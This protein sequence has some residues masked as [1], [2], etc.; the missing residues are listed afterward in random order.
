VENLLARM[1]LAEKVA[2]LG[3]AWFA[4]LVVD[5]DL[6]AERMEQ[7]LGQ[8]IGHISGIAPQSGRGPEEL[9]RF[10]NGIQ[11]FL[12]EHTRLGIPA[13]VHEEAVAGLCARGASQFPQ[14]IGLASTWDPG[15]VE[16]VAASC[17]RHL[18]AVGARAALSP[19]VD[20]ALD[21]RWGRLEETYGEDPELTSR[22]AVAYVRGMQGDDLAYGVAATAKH[23]VAH[24]LPEGGFNHGAV[25]IGARRLR[26]VVAAPFRATVH[27][28]GLANVMSAY[29]EV[30][31]LP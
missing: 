22:L 12:V 5:G 7:H 13:I 9:A 3:G 2:Q 30:D 23:F 29:H 24:G 6:D 28:A 14:A 4:D 8:G 26:D 20:L 21:P 17:R 11:R 25:S 16:E 31:G 27:E 18:L 15:L 1:T 19:V 10:A